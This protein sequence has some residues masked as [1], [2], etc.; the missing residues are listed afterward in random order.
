MAEEKENEMNNKASFE[1]I[2]TEKEK[3][4]QKLLDELDDTRISYGY[5][6]LLASNILFRFEDAISLIDKLSISKAQKEGF[7]YATGKITN[8]GD[9][10]AKLQELD[11]FRKNIKELNDQAVA[12]IEVERITKRIN[13]FVR[14]NGDYLPHTTI[15][16]DKTVFSLAHKYLYSIQ[17]FSRFTEVELQEYRSAIIRQGMTNPDIPKE[18]FLNAVVK[19]HIINNN[20]MIYIP[21]TIVGVSDKEKEHYEMIYNEVFTKVLSEARLAVEREDLSRDKFTR[22]VVGVTF[23]DEHNKVPRQDNIK[24]IKKAVDENRL[25]YPVSVELT[26]GIYTDKDGRNYDTVEVLYEGKSI[27]NL[28]QQFVGSL[29]DAYGK[30]SK[31]TGEITEINGGFEKA[32]KTASY[33]VTVNVYVPLEKIQTNE[34]RIRTAVRARAVSRDESKRPDRAPYQNRENRTVSRR[35]ESPEI[36]G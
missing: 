29:N 30:D 5:T 13:D 9:M 27:G 25:S 22:K 34:E 16:E 4:L 10:A 35:R 24:A 17:T 14:N 20:D 32:G 1:E 15:V 23:Q 8:Y 28:S 12:I 31:I 6:S 19:N 21:K 11:T 2:R 3:E 33:G 7:T 26:R 36:A 18:K